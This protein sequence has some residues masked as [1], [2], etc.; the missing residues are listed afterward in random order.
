[1]GRAATD[2]ILCYSSCCT[3]RPSQPDDYRDCFEAVG[4]SSLIVW[5]FSNDWTSPSEAQAY[6]IVNHLSLLHDELGQLTNWYALLILWF[7][8]LVC[9]VPVSACGG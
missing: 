1:M 5:H 8:I 6:F 9:R 2:W 4:S 3:G 7:Q